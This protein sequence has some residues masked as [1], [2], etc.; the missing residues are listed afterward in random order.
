[1]EPIF[2]TDNLLAPG[3]GQRLKKFIKKGGEYAVT[4]DNNLP[5]WGARLEGY[6]LFLGKDAKRDNFMY[7][8]NGDTIRPENN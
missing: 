2:Q 3:E 4:L 1:M 8:P 5:P 6:I 7:C